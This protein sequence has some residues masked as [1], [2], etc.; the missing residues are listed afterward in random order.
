MEPFFDRANGG[1]GQL[2][3]ELLFQ[4]DPGRKLFNDSFCRRTYHHQ[5]INQHLDGYHPDAEHH[6]ALINA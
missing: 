2:A 4:L 1:E 5:A 6:D 3:W